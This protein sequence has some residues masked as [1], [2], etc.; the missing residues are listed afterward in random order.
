[1]S[2]WYVRSG[3]AGTANGFNW[4]NAYTTVNTALNATNTAVGDTLWVSDDHAELF[5]TTALTISSPNANR[6]APTYVVCANHTSG[7]Q[8]PLPATDLTFTANITSQ[9]TTLVLANGNISW[10][11]IHF[12][13]GLGNSSANGTISLTTPTAMRFDGCSFNQSGNAGTINLPILLGGGITSDTSLTFNN[14][15]FLFTQVNHG[16]ALNGAAVTML[17]CNAQSNATPINSF[18]FANGTIG[19]GGSRVRIRS[20]DLSKVN[21]VYIANT[22]NTVTA[23]D[24]RFDECNMPVSTNLI[25][26]NTSPIFPI[27]VSGCGGQYDQSYVD[28]FGTTVSSNTT[29]RLG[30]AIDNQGYPKSIQVI[31]NASP[32]IGFP[33]TAGN[34]MTRWNTDTADVLTATVYG[35]WANNTPPTNAMIWLEV[36]YFANATSDVTSLSTSGV[37]GNNEFRISNFNLPVTLT[38][39]PVSRWVGDPFPYTSTSNN[40]FVLQTSFQAARQGIVSASVKTTLTN[41]SNTNTFFFDPIVYITNSTGG[42]VGNTSVSYDTGTVT[43]SETLTP[44]T[45]IS[46]TSSLKYT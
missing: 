28:Y 2:N 45:I 23:S 32:S 30:G 40:L 36:E 25:D 29:Y 18:L 20:S 15:N 33:F 38:T 4:T 34:P 41:A 35:M 46:S 3:A 8:P 5:T 12:N 14:C 22:A 9:D 16:F 6:T 39:D 10:S 31:P 1:M 13:A 37:S 26:G 21:A 17:G 27:Q 7:N 44:D 11:G 43:I 24:I 19:S 42:V